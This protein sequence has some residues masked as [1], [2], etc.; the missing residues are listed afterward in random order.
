M[1][2]RN[3]RDADAAAVGG[4]ACEPKR[5]SDGQAPRPHGQPP[6]TVEEWDGIRDEVGRAIGD[7]AHD[8]WLTIAFTANVAWAE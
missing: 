5:D 4:H 7:E 2:F 8:R 1:D 6:R 3:D